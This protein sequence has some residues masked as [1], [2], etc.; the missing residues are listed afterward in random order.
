MVS[1]N[2]FDCHPSHLLDEVRAEAARVYLLALFATCPDAK[3]ANGWPLE[4]KKK[5]SAAW[6]RHF[7]DNKAALVTSAEFILAAQLK[8]YDVSQ[9]LEYEPADWT[10][11]P[12]STGC[13]FVLKDVR[14]VKESRNIVKRRCLRHGPKC[15]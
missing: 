6:T 13:R 8:Y 11:P 12:N 7:N 3:D 2:P 1:N 15:N 10:S 14:G 5:E 4:D 9:I